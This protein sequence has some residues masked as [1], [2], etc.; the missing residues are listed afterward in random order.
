MRPSSSAIAARRILL[1]AKLG[2]ALA[3]LHPSASPIWPPTGF[4]L[5]IVLLRGYR[6]VAGDPARR[7]SSPMRRPPARG[8]TAAAIAAGNALE[9]LARRRAD[10][11]LVGRARHLCDAAQRREVRADLSRRGDARSAPPSASAPCASRAPPHWANFAAIWVTW[12]LGD[13]AGAL[14]HHAGDR[15]VGRRAA[16][17]SS[18]D[19]RS[20]ES[21]AIFVAT[22]VL[23][24]IAFS[25]LIEQTPV[26]DPL[27]FLAILPLL[28]AALRRGQRDTATVALILAG[29]AIWG[30]LARGGPFARPNLNDSFLLLLMF[31]I[32]ISVP[33]LALSATIAM[34][35]RTEADCS[36]EALRHRTAR[37]RRPRWSITREQL[38]QAQKME[39]LGQL[40]GGIAHDF[41]NL[42]M[43]VSGHAQILHRRLKPTEPRHHPGARSDPAPPPSA[44]RT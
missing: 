35:R 33:S 30:T 37:G 10:Q 28:W 39:A 29:F 21:A 14:V 20:L 9:A 13:L 4:A 34:R 17:S 31:L 6:V 2:L 19:E 26:R 18:R 36:R 16:Y 15:A 25:P 22:C 40:T 24:L 27:G 23:G 38:A 7:A 12:W 1:L 32:S 41:N 3:S 11:S 42:L 44:A 5:A 8:A 43:I